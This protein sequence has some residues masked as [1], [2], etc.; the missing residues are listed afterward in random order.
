MFNYWIVTNEYKNLKKLFEQQSGLCKYSGRTLILQEN[1]ELD[2]IMPKAKGGSDSLNNLQWLHRS[3]NKMKYD[4]TES[5]FG[6]LIQD[7]VNNQ[8][9]VRISTPF[10]VTSSVCSNCADNPPSTVT[11]VQPSLS[12]LA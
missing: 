10:S 4:F 12:I 5:E 1:C 11:A 6:E 9:L 7:I 8:L 2:H 3:I